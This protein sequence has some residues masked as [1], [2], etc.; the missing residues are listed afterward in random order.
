MGMNRKKTAALVLGALLAGLPAGQV[1]GSG[2][3][4]ALSAVRLLV[5]PAVLS[6]LLRLLNADP[7]VM[8]IAVLQI[9][10]P[11]AVNGSMLCLE[12]GGVS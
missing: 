6:F 12:F 4:W 10:M 11:V 2:R 8:S 5:L 1:F 9:A 3:L 7:F